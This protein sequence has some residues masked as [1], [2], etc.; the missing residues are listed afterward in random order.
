MPPSFG[1]TRRWVRTSKPSAVR[2]SRVRSRRKRFWKQPPE[3]ATRG[4]PARRAT[5]AMPATRALWKRAERSG[6]VDAARAVLEES[7]EERAPVEERGRAGGRRRDERE[8]VGASLGRVGERLERHRGLPLEARLRVEAD[9]RRDGVEEASRARRDGAARAGRDHPREE[10]A[11]RR[12][13]R[14][15]GG[16]VVAV[17]GALA[18]ELEEE[19]ERGPARLLHGGVAAGKAEGS[20]VRDARRSRPRRRAGTRRPRPCRRFRSRCRPR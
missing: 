18:E 15:D 1:G 3:S 13:E 7:E 10:R 20:Q 8:R 2:R 9:E 11:L 19:R 6:D 5:A 12:G 14:R 4:E 16:E 17:E